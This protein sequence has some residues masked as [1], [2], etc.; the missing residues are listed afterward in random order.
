MKRLII[1]LIIALIS[2]QLAIGQDDAPTEPI[3][4]TLTFSSLNLPSGP[5]TGYNLTMEGDATLSV[6]GVGSKA[7]YFIVGA[8]PA[9]YRKTTENNIQSFDVPFDADANLRITAMT[10]DASEV[11]INRLPYQFAYG[12]SVDFGLDIAFEGSMYGLIFGRALSNGA[13]KVNDV[14]GKRLFL[15]NDA[16]GGFTLLKDDNALQSFDVS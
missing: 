12:D 1:T 8:Q 5:V 4:A 11:V 6:L 2:I 16:D 7:V 9:F 3:S 15:Y 10:E 13:I 14:A